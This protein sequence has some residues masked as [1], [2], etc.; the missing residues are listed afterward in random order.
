MPGN[1]DATRAQFVQQP[2][3]QDASVNDGHGFCSQPRHHRGA[4][5]LAQIGKTNSHLDGGKL[6]VAGGCAPR[7]VGDDAR[8]HANLLGDMVEHD[9]RQQFACAQVSPR[10]TRQY[11]SADGFRRGF[12]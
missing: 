10:L 12:L 4:N 2:V 9:R 11:P 1:D 7:E 3:E 8:I 5:W 6:V